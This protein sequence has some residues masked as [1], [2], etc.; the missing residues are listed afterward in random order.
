MMRPMAVVAIRTVE[1]RGRAVDEFIC[2]SLVLSM[3]IP[4]FPPAAGVLCT[5]TDIPS[6]R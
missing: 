4:Y 1:I 5:A 3:F 2:M 6:T